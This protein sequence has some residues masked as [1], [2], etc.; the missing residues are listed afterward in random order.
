MIDLHHAQLMTSDIDASIAFWRDG[1]AGEVIADMPMDGARNVFMRVGDGRIRLCE[2]VPEHHGPGTIRH[3]GIQT[4]DLTAVV[5]RL[6]TI[7]VAAG[8]VHGSASAAYAIVHGPD[9]LVLEVFQLAIDELP[10]DLRNFFDG[11]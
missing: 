4:D 5:D 2:Q 11:G 9:G 10:S 7:G 3:L 1:F 8:E 6:N